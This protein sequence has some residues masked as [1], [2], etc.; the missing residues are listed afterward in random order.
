[1]YLLL[2]NNRAMLRNYFKIMI[3]NLWKRKVFTLINLLGLSFGMAICIL[4]GLYIHNELGYDNFHERGD[5]IYRLALERK[6]P[7]R[8]AFKGKIPRSIGEAVKKEFP[9]VLESVRVMDDGPERVSINIDGKLLSEN[10]ILTVDSNFFRVFTGNFI[11]GDKQT[12]LQKPGTVVLNESTA[13]WFFGSPEKAMGRGLSINGPLNKFI[14]AGV[15]SDW[16]EK[17]HLQ[18]NILTTTSGVPFMSEPEYVYFGPYTYLLLNKNVSAARLE[19]K[20]L[21]VVNKY[22][23][24]VISPLFGESYKQFVTEGNGYRYFLQ[25]I[26]DIHLNSNL[27]DELLPAGS[28]RS[29]EVLSVIAIFILFLACINFINLSTAVSLERAREVGIRKTFGSDRKQLM[30]QFITES[31]LF[32]L[33]CLI[34]AMLLVLLLIPVMNNISGNEL[35]FRFLLNPWRLVSVFGFAIFVGL[36]AGLYPALVLSSFQPMLVLK[37]KFRSNRFGIALRNGLVVFQ[38]AISVILIICTIMVN[39]QMQYMTSDRIGFK[40]DH[41][42][43]IERVGFLRGMQ[44]GDHRASFAN[45]ISKI[46]GVENITECDQLPGHD[47]SGGG[48][49]WVALDNNASRTQRML[50]VDDNYAKLLDLEM[51]EGRFFSKEYSTDSLSVILNET[52]VED[53]GLKNP[54]GARLISKEPYMN[55][56]NGKSQNIFTVVGVLKDFHYQSMRRK[57]APLII[58]NSNKFGWG[59]VGVRIRGNQFKT[60]LAEIEKTWEQFDPKDPFLFDFLDQNLAALY[61]S[62]QTEQKI[63][64][65][66][67]LLAIGIASIGLFGLTAYS[68]IQRSREIGIRRVLGAMPGNIIMILSGNFLKLVVIAAF[69]AFP[70]AWWIMYEWLQNFSYRVDIPLWVFLLAGSIATLIA[71]LT[72]SYQAIRAAVAKPVESLRSE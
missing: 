46:A 36:L 37:G 64:T 39:R 70:F 50:Q 21:Y 32:S 69:I 63:F 44:G 2:G 20:L 7:G 28:M 5:Q 45:E 24:P 40:K 33:F 17:S 14:V 15:C 10:K 43:T 68:T 3:R 13:R 12:A 25:S 22:V 62:E 31:V 60:T 65:I 42:I 11:Q 8:S 71:M 72:I 35:S 51:K 52:A 49:T 18:F 26:K 19:N 66:F 67:S 48:A 27:E 30:R 34:V 54:I 53:F 55:P 38:F 6:Y 58:I 41:I 1:M 61:K 23:A 29:I 16:P 59:S 4:L 57:I 9:E 56:P 47:E